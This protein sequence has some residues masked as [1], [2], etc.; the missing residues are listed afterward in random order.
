M[1]PSVRVEAALALGMLEGKGAP[2]PE[3]K[4]LST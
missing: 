1:D 3:L 4:S 2:P